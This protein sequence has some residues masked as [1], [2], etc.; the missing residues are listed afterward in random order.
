MNNPLLDNEFLTKLTEHRQ[1]EVYARITLLTQNEL[2]VEYIEGRVSAGSISV[3]GTSALRRTCNLTM[4]LKDKT[5]VNQFNWTFKS[6]FKLEVGLKNFVDNR[7]PDII[8]FKQGIFILTTCN[9]NQ[10]TNN[11]TITINGKDKMCLLNGDLGGNIPHSTDFG[12]EEYYNKVTGEVTYNKVLLKNIIRNALQTFGG[13]LPENIIINDLDEAGLEL[14]EYR[15]EDEPLY[16]FRNIEDYQID[17]VTLDPNHPVWIDGKIDRIVSSDDIIYAETSNLQAQPEEPTKV[18]LKEG[19]NEP[20]YEIIKFEYGDLAGYRLTDLTYAGEL[21]CNIGETI[22]SIL[23]KIKKMLVDFEYFYNLDGKFVFQKK[24]TYISTPWGGVEKDENNGINETI[25]DAHPKINLM[26]AQL[27]T[28]FANNPNLL[29]VKND[30]SVWG[31]YKS[32]SGADIPIHMRYAI[33]TKPKEYKPIRAVWTHRADAENPVES[34][35]YLDYL[36]F[37][38]Y[39]VVTDEETNM[40]SYYFKGKFISDESLR[41]SQDDILT[42]WREIIYQMALDYYALWEEDDFYLMVAAANPTYPSGRTGYEQYYTDL[43]GFWRQLY[44]PKPE[45]LYEEIAAEKVATEGEIQGD[46]YVDGYYHKLSKEELT[47]TEGSE[48]KRVYDLKDLY[49]IQEIRVKDA[50][51]FEKKKKVFYP[52]IESPRCC[53]LEGQ[54]YWYYTGTGYEPSVDVDKLNAKSLTALY[55]DIGGDE[56]ELVVELRY[57]DFIEHYGEDETSFWIKKEGKISL[58]KLRKDKSILDLIYRDGID[59]NKDYVQLL[60]RWGIKDNYGNFAIPS[61]DKENIPQEI[62]DRVT[63]VKEHENGEYSPSTHWN[64]SV[65]GSPDQ[66]IFWFDFLDI[67]GSDLYKYSVKEIGSRTKS[68]N[69]SNVKSIYYRDVPNVIFVEDLS[70]FNYDKRAGYT[71][72]QL[73]PGY[74]SLFSISERGKSAKERI[75]ELLQEHSYAIEQTNITT[76]PLYHLEPNTRVSVKDEMS[77]VDGEYIVTKVIIPLAYNGTM[78]LSTTKVVSNIM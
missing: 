39:N 56:R 37:D 77:N 10:T 24:H 75:D 54:T 5:E 50:D 40:T 2:P 73:P 1:R 18:S 44:D 41:E 59:S 15:Y 58:N 65:Q 25:N 78:S 42:D 53:L 69:D 64:K 60:S 16:L 61:D 26:N 63:Y 3:D 6:K 33:D 21:K 17:N 70:D 35:A 22:V 48:T 31:T 4:T 20:I 45:A 7:Y 74:V 11:Y 76:V 38:R 19:D 57:N 13:E 43:Q 27:V 8:W 67:D 23:D 46:I 52:F 72:I 12:V 47:V 14:L 66:L 32:I 30:F 49:I 51:G 62:S 71:Y 68:I 36:A 34:D 9:M 55:E 29:N 28:A